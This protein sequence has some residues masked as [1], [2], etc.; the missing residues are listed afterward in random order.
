MR[1]PFS[2]SGSKDFPVT[3]KAL[4]PW[5]VFGIFAMYVAT[6]ALPLPVRSG[7]GFDVTAFGRLPVL[8]NGRVQPFDSVARTGLL[9]IRG[10]VTPIDGL[11]AAQARPTMIDPTVWLLEVLAKPDTADTRRIFPI[12]SHELLGKLQLQVPGRGTNYYAFNDLGPKASEIQKQV[13]QFANVKASDRTQWQEELIALR[14]SLVLYERLKNSL[15]P[16]TRLQQDARGKPI[17]FDFAAELGKFQVDMGEALRVDAARRRGSPERLEVGAERRLRTLAALF[18]VVAR[19]GMLAVVPRANLTTSSSDWS[20]IGSLVVQSALGRQPPAPV[21]FFAG[22]SSAFAQDKPE[23]FNSQVAQYRQWLVA[24]GHG[25]DVKK[26]G[27]EAFSNL[28]LPLA[29]AAVL[30]LVALILAI[31]AWRT[32]SATVVR[33]ALMMVLLASALHATGLVFAT[34]LAGRPSWIAF[35]GWAIGLTALVVERIRRSGYGTMASAAIGLTALVAAYGVAPGG[36]ASLFRN[37]VE[38]SLL[39]AIAATVLVLYA[40]SESRWARRPATAPQAT[41]ESPLA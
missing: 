21:A 25:A 36:A 16:N 10:A 11:K 30:Y 6:S 17:S 40:G 23:A 18:Q 32:R 5:I 37:V 4:V 38:T 20:N 35:S 26:G 13:Q 3:T 34:V 29:R 9:Q 7:S 28:L 1:S 27:F 41:L 19:T 33:S 12:K 15:E 2:S 24:N 14:D 39:L 22:M 31:V 8:A